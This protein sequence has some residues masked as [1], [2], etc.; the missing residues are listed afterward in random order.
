[1]LGKDFEDK[2]VQWRVIDVKWSAEYSEVVVFYYDAQDAD[3]EE[4]KAIDATG[5]FEGFG[6]GAVEMSTL[7][8]A[9]K[10][11]KESTLVAKRGGWEVGSKRRASRNGKRAD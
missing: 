8:K 2:G 10:W 4:L 5:D 11:I 6:L 9:V 7:S 3:E 1:V